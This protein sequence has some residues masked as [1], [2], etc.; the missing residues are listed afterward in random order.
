[1]Y[2]KIL[3]TIIMCITLITITGCNTVEKNNKKESR[4][5]DSIKFKEE[6]ESLNNKDL[7]YG[8]LRKLNIDED[9]P[10]VY[11]SP[12]DIVKLMDNKET[13]IVYFG[14]NSCP[15]CR[16]IIETLIEVSKDNNIDTIYYVDVKEIRDV[17]VLE[18]DKAITETKGTDGYYKLL[19]YFDEVLDDY[20][21]NN[22]DGDIIKTGEKRIYAPNVIVVK[23]GKPKKL[24]T[25]ISE[26]QTK[27]NMKLTDEIKEDTYNQFK[28]LFKL[29]KEDSNVCTKNSKC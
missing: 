22:D 14:F 15:W 23:D 13:F 29:I 24:V 5:T 20:T 4:V 17:M 7:G 26:K 28:D 25:G 21:L 8:E 6:Y 18:D 19:E 16:S 12:N 3:L 9:N 2:K 11:K 1:M 10:F 27:P